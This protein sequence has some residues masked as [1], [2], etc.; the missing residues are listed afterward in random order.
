M[1]HLQTESKG[2][3]SQHM[4]A[5]YTSELSCCPD[6]DHDKSVEPHMQLKYTYK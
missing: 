4:D 2:T 1:L 6:L 3:L 5:S